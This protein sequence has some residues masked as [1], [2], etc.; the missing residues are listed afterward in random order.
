MKFSFIHKHLHAG[1]QVYA[2]K[3]AHQKSGNHY[4]Q[5]IETPGQHLTA[6]Q[7]KAKFSHTLPEKIIH[8]KALIVHSLIGIVITPLHCQ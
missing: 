8:I 2:E 4:L 3:P 6:L 7:N 5:P 1:R